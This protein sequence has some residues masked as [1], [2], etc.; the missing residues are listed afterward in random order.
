MQWG[1]LCLKKKIIKVDK[2]RK[3]NNSHGKK[4]DGQR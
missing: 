3:G 4:P 2:D 1:N